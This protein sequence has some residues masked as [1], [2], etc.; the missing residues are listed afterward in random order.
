ML[1]AGGRQDLFDVRGFL[2]LHQEQQW[3]N[4]FD[5]HAKP[6][7]TYTRNLLVFFGKLNVRTFSPRLTT[8]TTPK[9]KREEARRKEREEGFDLRF[10]CSVP[11]Y[12]ALRDANMRYYFES[13]T[14]Q[15]HL[16]E[17]GQVDECGR[18]LD[19]ERRRSRLHVVESEIARAERRQRSLEREEDHARS[20]V[21][22]ERFRDI[23]RRR[24]LGNVE[25]QRLEVKNQLK[26][27]ALEREVLGHAHLWKKTDKGTCRE[28]SA[29]R[30]I[31][32]CPKALGSGRR[33][34][35]ATV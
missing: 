22:Q 19:R 12:N 24:R 23:D 30:A 8:M 26:L 27:S 6:F 7:H 33:P 3:D 35:R 32:A 4:F 29:S 18:I 17:T 20:L 34:P 13:P 11:E 16:L 14:V 5:K 28:S 15:E 10:S 2:S 1:F 21:R 9:S 25:R 31:E